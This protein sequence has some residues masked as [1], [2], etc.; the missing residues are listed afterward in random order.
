[1]KK[2]IGILGGMG[3]E[4]TAYMYNLI[5]K[6]T[7]VEKDQDH[8]PVV[9][10]SYPKIPP[11]TDAIDGTGPSPAPYMEEG[12]RVLLRAGADFIIMPC[13]TAHYFMPEVE[14]NVGFD[15]LSLLDEALAW[16]K[17]NVPGLKTAGIISSSGTLKSRLFH[18][19]F[20]K[21]NIDI[22]AP[23][24][25]E[26]EQVMEAIFGSEGIKAGFTSGPSKETIVGMAKTLIE[27]G[28]EAIIAGCTEV[29]LVLK[30]A[31]ISVPFIE[32]MQ[33][34]AEAAIQTAGYKLKGK[35]GV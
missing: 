14:Q 10:Y 22:I 32:P 29:P 4:A 11:R 35:E 5:I 27:R 19:T 8:I 20:A 21:E 26:Q 18:D 33:I 9:I 7:R 2:V 30:A 13:V 28:A 6:N 12:V 3:P 31:D 23:E 17:K 25:E 1:M 24:T 16:A 15:F 34:M